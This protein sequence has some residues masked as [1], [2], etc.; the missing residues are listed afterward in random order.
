[1]ALQGGCGILIY[2][3]HADGDGN[4]ALEME[5]DGGPPPWRAANYEKFGNE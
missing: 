2:P 4:L 5:E 1:M 3:I